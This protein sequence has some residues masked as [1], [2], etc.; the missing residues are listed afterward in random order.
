MKDQLFPSS[1][2]RAIEELRPYLNEKSATN[3]SLCV[4][5]D[6]AIRVGR[7]DEQII[8]TGDLSVEDVHFSLDYMTL[9]EAGF[10]AMVSNLSDCAAMGAAPDGA[11]VQVVVPK[12]IGDPREPL[13]E[14]YRGISGAVSKWKTPLVGGDLSRGPCWVISITLL[15]RR[16][17]TPPPRI[18]TRRGMRSGDA[19]F[20]TGNVGE[21]SAGLSAL[22]RWGRSQVPERFRQLVS[23]HISPSPRIAQGIILADDPYIH[24]MMDIS[25]GVAKECLTLAFDNQMGIVLEYDST[26]VS[27]AV[28]ELSEQLK[29]SWN[30]WFLDGGEDYELI[31][32]A[33]VSW[34]P[35]EMIEGIS[36]R[37]IGSVSANTR[38]VQVKREGHLVPIER[39]GWDHL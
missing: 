4:G 15:G 11:V 29:V 38:G 35:P 30:D 34:P 1:E 21:S 9:E 33:D 3:Y 26:I 25:D 6:A 23:R 32:T 2:Y 39:G 31:F 14:L 13:R 28:R 7:G 19:V 8:L 36:I 37:R 22:R 24:C 10:R 5:D 18:L 20:V 16:T 27:T 17:G 12:R